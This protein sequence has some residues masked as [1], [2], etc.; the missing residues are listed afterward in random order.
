M[1][2]TNNYSTGKKEEKEV[3]GGGT[4]PV[5]AYKAPSVEAAAQNLA[6]LRAGYKPEQDSAVMAAKSKLDALQKPSQSA[7]LTDRKSVV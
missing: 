5:Q 4:L 3:T 1:A 2:Y 7:Q 6:Q